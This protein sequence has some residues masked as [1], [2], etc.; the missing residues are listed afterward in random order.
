MLNPVLTVAGFKVRNTFVST[1]SIFVARNVCGIP[2]LGTEGTGMAMHVNKGLACRAVSP[3]LKKQSHEAMFCCCAAMNGEA[4][5]ELPSQA[6]LTDPSEEEIGTIG[7]PVLKTRQTFEVSIPTGENSNLGLNVDETSSLG[8]MVL[9]IGEGAVR[10]FNMLNP[11]DAVQ[12]YDVITQ[13][14]ETMGA[15]LGV[16]VRSS[17]YGD[18]RLTLRRP[19]KV[20]VS[21]SKTATLGIKLDYRPASLG[22]IVRGVE[23]PGLLHTWNSEHPDDAVG[24]Q[25]RIIALNDKICLGQELVDAIKAEPELRFTVLKY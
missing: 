8:P 11:G 16:Q 18:V 6:A 25:D 24:D 9:E 22:V 3:S 21:V 5:G 7:Q 14:G 10:N 17:V 2:C 15:A 4:V 19:R 1:G 12:P 20:E 23:E 13:M